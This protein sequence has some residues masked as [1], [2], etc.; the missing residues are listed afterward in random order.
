MGLIGT[1]PSL[2]NNQLKLA[3]DKLKLDQ[4]CLKIIK[5]IKFCFD[6]DK[7]QN[8]LILINFQK[9]FQNLDEK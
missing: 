2:T 5:I 8:F 4:A 7:C 3:E 1:R 6:K 9:N